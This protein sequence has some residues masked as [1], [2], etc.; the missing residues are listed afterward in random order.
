M[1]EFNLFGIPYVGAD[2]CGF[3]ENSTPE[4]CA[5]WSSLG[6]FSPF[7]RNHNSEKNI[8]QDPVITSKNK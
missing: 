8:P 4:L 3:F 5:R 7:S 6:A 1:L 2:I